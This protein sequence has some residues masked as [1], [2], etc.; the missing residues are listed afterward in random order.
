[1]ILGGQHYRIG[2]VGW[3]VDAVALGEEEVA[4]DLADGFA[5]IEELCFCLGL[6]VL[7]LAN[8]CFLAFGVAGAVFTKDIGV[9]GFDCDDAWAIIGIVVPDDGVHG[10]FVA[11]VVFDVG[12][13][14]FKAY[15]GY[16]ADGDLR[17][18]GLHNPRNDGFFSFVHQLDEWTEEVEGH[19]LAGEEVV[20]EAVFF[21]GLVLLLAHDSQL[22]VLKRKG[23]KEV[24][25][26]LFATGNHAD[27]QVLR[28]AEWADAHRLANG[29][30][31]AALKLA[32]FP[33]E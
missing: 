22:G 27:L 13:E 32:A 3:F 17:E 16:L 11:E 31:V 10:S 18:D 21:D 26:G 28:G 2:L 5:T 9:F 14:V 7:Q 19:G 29:L 23:C 15:F 25:P 4:I 24:L 6:E 1:M 8:Q 12:V 33:G 30:A 20:E